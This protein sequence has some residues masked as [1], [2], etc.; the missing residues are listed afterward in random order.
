MLHGASSVGSR[1]FAAQIPLFSRRFQLLV[2]DARGH[3]RT[4]W[5]AANGFRYDW[6]VEDLA[7]F[8]DGLGLASFHLLGFSMGAMTALMFA[9]RHPERLRT[10]AIVGITT[11]REPRLS[12][13]RRLTNLERIDREDPAWARELAARHD[14]GQGEGAWRRLLAGIADDVAV[15]PLL[16]PGDLRRIDAPALVTVGDRDPFVPVDH[17]WGISRQ[18]GD[19]RLFVVPGCGHEVTARRPGLFN[20][21][22]GAFFRSTETVARAR[23]EAPAAVRPRP[24]VR[25]VDN[26]LESDPDDVEPDTAWL[27]GPVDPPS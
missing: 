3:G 18:L 9:I 4:R 20:E 27:A 7:A 16:A 14:P 21:A 10:L 13:L 6:L 11:Q 19:G 24:A 12:V 17:A 22:L 26:P 23:A 15:Q 1:D 5:D 25:A 2:P 8:V